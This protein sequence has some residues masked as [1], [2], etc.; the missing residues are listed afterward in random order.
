MQII[1]C[2]R[3]HL[4][5]SSGNNAAQ[6]KLTTGAANCGHLVQKALRIM[7]LTAFLIL[8]TCLQVA[9]SDGFGQKVTLSEREVPVEKIFNEIKKQT[10]FNFLYTSNLLANAH[11][12]TVQVTNAPVNEVLDIALAGQGLEYRVKGE[13]KLIIIKNKPVVKTVAEAGTKEGGPID[14]S[15][16]VTDADGHALPGANVQVRGSNIGVITDKDGRFSLKDIPE[17]SIL[18]ITYV[19]HEMKTL[20]VRGGGLVNIAL[21]QKLSMMDETVV[22][23]YW[24]TTNRLKTG[25][26]SVVKAEDIAKQPVNN[27]L[28]ALQGRVPGLFIT[29]ANGLPGSGIQVAI[30]GK[31]SINRGNEPFYVIDGVPYTSLLLPN[32]G[33]VLGSS[34]QGI[35]ATSGNPLSFLNPADIE[36]ISV[37]K[38]ADATA[39]YGSRGANGVILI[40]TKK[41]KSGQTKVDVNLQTGWGKVT[42]TLDLLNTQKYLEMRHEAKIN[43]NESI[44]TTDYDINGFWDTT[45]YTDWQKELIG[46]TAHYTDVNANVS[47][48][49]ANTQIL[50]GAGYHRETTVFP[51]SL[52]D[53]RGSLH[54][55]IINT[56][57]NQ[58]FKMQL[59]GNYLEDNNRI[60]SGDLTEAAIRFAPNAPKIYNEDGLLNWMPD[61]NGASTWDN[62]LAYLYN[63][64]KNKTKS[65]VGNAMLSY[66]IVPGLEI[67]SSFGYTNLQSNDIATFPLISTRP[68]FRSFI[69]RSALYSNNNISSWIIEPQISY[70]TKLGNSRL[71]GLLGTTIQ[72]NMSNGLQIRGSGFNS[73]VVLDDIKSAPSI[74]ID[75]TV[76]TVYKYNALFARL[77]YNLFDKYLLN[78]T[79]RRDGSSRFGPGSQFHNFGAAGIGWIFS[80]EGVLKKYLPWISFGKVTASYGS[81]GNDQIGDYQFMTLYNNSFSVGVPYQGVN[82]LQPGTLS[83]GFLQWEETKKLQV[84]LDI[85]LFKERVSFTASYF[86]NRSSNQLLNYYLPI[87]TG[88]GSIFR[89]LPANVQNSGWEFT[90]NTSNIN[91]KNF[92]W[93]CDFNITIPKNLLLKFPSIETTGYGSTYIV[94]EPITI[95][96][97]YS[98]GGV[99]PSSGVYQFFDNKGNLTSAPDFSTD[100]TILINTAPIV[101]GGI[102]NN[103][104]FGGVQLD[105]LFQFIKRKG[106]NYLFGN[107]TGAYFNINQPISILN[108][109]QKPGDKTSI[110][111]YNSNFSLV[112]QSLYANE[113]D[114]SYADASFVRLKNLSL[115]YT[116]PESWYRGTK[117]N[118]VRLYMQ[119]QNLFTITNYIG[120]DPETLSSTT[121][122][123]L[124]VFTIGLQMGF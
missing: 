75:G 71:E 30:Q 102:K 36:S 5:R 45:R 96:K 62:P 55:S 27:P 43:D 49:T 60:I 51:G 83:N 54:F 120:L 123:T 25:N 39:I 47:G 80:K 18:E 88:L 61:A 85:S 33:S 12:V 26:V 32:Y 53:E 14:V 40:T 50:V 34:A 15:G 84:G 108:R 42:R 29:Q 1:V 7:K 16:R 44:Y 112:N 10:G 106:L 56:S 107:A 6:P 52:S 99:D 91:T 35:Q 113:S 4:L 87:Q 8:A 17:N 66:Q 86:C 118:N 104:K 37:L 20:N 94:G 81:T 3:W 11:K 64:Y 76:N 90:L 63:R 105:F 79:A 110:Q 72:Q 31:N 41:G 103:F 119:G 121:L 109:W 82:G 58:R 73:D 22:V 114:A 116:M 100:R 24:N 77:S 21:E 74:T 46:N 122:P 19:G 101:F 2:K 93:S 97:V 57:T 89:N 124:K 111:R 48:G 70:I 28:L 67:K 23:G 117:L 13:D 95:T 68:D 59:T 9:A 92:S 78:L 115:S 98:F 38:D 65:L 69:Q